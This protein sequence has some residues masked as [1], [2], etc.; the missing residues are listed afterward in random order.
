[1]DLNPYQLTISFITGLVSGFVVSVPV[2]P[3]NISIINDG[4]RRGFLYGFLIGLGSV[5]MEV[6]YCSVAF[7]SFAGL[8]ESRT[9][10]AVMELISFLL[11]TWLGLKYVLAKSLPPTPHS[12]EVVEHRLHPHTAYM[13]GFVR[14]LGN[15]SVLLFWITLSAVFLSHGWIT[16]E[17]DDK[18]ACV[19]GVGLGSALWFGALSWA[20]SVGHKKFSDR[21]LLIFSR[22]SG[23]SLL[24]VSVVIGVR[25][26]KLLAKH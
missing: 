21:T 26:V 24:I 3:T 20:V 12:L 18:I 5:T 23:G 15:P 22:I 7:A 16:P 10:R 2:G 19:T 14:V 25:L 8:F 1:M 17:W 4:G 13:T 9:A 6:V 11:V